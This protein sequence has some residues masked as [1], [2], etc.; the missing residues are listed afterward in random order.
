MIW[1]TESKKTRSGEH[2]EENENFR[3]PGNEREKC[4]A[5][6]IEAGAEPWEAFHPF[7]H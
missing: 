3:V 5:Q 6:G 1:P 7:G 4:L 2:R